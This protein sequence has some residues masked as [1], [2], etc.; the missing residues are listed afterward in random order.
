MEIYS[1]GTEQERKNDNTYESLASENTGIT[2]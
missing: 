2:L 1:F